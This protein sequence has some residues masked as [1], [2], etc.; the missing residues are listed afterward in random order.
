MIILSIVI[1][2]V[3]GVFFTLWFFQ[4]EIFNGR[5]VGYGKN[6]I[7]PD[8]CCRSVPYAQRPPKQ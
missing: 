3:V 6:D 1:G 4:E 7:H 2:F 8:S 5:K